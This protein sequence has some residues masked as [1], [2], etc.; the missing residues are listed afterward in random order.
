MLI[1]VVIFLAVAIAS[2]VI[3]GMGTTGQGLI[4]RE[5]DEPG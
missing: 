5:K 4:A 2:R 1:V 3:I